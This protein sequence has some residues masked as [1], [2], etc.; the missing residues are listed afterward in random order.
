MSKRF[1]RNQKK[2]LK[3]KLDKLI[4]R[5]KAL[6]YDYNKIKSRCNDIH[7]T[8]ERVL[9]NSILLP[10]K[11]IPGDTTLPKFALPIYES[12]N[13]NSL[14]TET[15]E[16][17]IIDLHKLDILIREN[18][19]TLQKSVHLMI[20]DRS[21]L[22]YYL[23]SNAIKNVSEEYLFNYFLPKVTKELVKVLQEKRGV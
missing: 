18:R 6:A 21:E 16:Y 20:S 12:L 7:I 19:E 2:R 11:E 1:G 13:S 22:C 14:T 17:K 5:N 4:N 3:E 8:I 9:N 23:S 10:P 15:L